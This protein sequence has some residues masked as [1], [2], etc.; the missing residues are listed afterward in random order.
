MDARPAYEA[1]R[2]QELVWRAWYK[3]ARWQRVR[4][5]QLIAQP[6]CAMCKARGVDRPATVC[7]HIVRH[8]GNPDL[9][10]RGPFN[11]LCKNCH[12]SDQQRIEGGSTARPIIDATGWPIG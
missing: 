7:N 4:K 6:L 2:N 9:F 5:Q 3:T 11:S 1:R 12:D 10:W 8:N